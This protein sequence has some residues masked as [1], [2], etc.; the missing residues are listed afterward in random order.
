M[1]SV[2]LRNVSKV[3]DRHV[4]AVSDLTLAV[5]DGQF[6]VLVGP[7]GCGKTTTLRL[8]AG[9]ETPTAGDISI[10]NRVVTDVPARE[11]D[12]AL[13]FQDSALYPHMDVY[14]NMAFARR[15]Q[16]RPE[17]EIRQRVAAAAEMLGISDLLQRKPATLSGGQRRRV[18][19]GKAIVREPA[20]FLF[21]EPLS[22]LDAQLHLAMRSEL[23]SLHQR[24]GTT[25]LHVTHDQAEAMALGQQICVLREGWVQQVGPPDLRSSGQSICCWLLRDTAH[26]LSGGSGPVSGWIVLPCRR[27]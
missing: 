4:T 18:A 2:S 7:S 3:F 6:M 16:K 11:R 13:V 9:L 19:L 1:G 22:N 14:G 5:P 23:K 24:L 8:I 10:A 21:D 25:C 27:K 12:V 20:V 15:M 26:E 17:A